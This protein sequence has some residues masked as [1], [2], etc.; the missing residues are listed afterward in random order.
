MRKRRRA[1]RKRKF[2]AMK[3]ERQQKKDNTYLM[4]DKYTRGTKE[5]KVVD[6]EME[7]KKAK[8]KKEKEIEGVNA[9]DNI[10]L[11]LLLCSIILWGF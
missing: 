4:L 2:R 8:E 7:K 3:E 11:S 1:R 5:K 9:T 6:F 10:A